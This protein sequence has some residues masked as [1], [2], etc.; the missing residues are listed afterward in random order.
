MVY[1][2]NSNVECVMGEVQTDFI[3][4]VHGINDFG[5]IGVVKF[6]SG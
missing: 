2:S 5:G 3:R 6:S 1:L 4:N